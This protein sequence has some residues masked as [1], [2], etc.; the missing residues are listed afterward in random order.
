MSDREIRLPSFNSVV[1]AG[2]ATADA[3]IRYTPKGAAVLNFNIGVNRSYKDKTTDEWVSESSF[4][5][6][7]VWNQQAERVAERLRKGS[8]VVVEGELRQ[9][10]WETDSGDKRS[11][12]EVTARRV[13]V[14]DKTHSEG[15][16][17]AAPVTTPTEPVTDDGSDI[18]F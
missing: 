7:T 15:G 14:L 17:Q 1:L 8:A 3:E 16:E 12:V 13:Q 2:Y 5:A 18:P 11:V 9:R 6:V 4:F 10:R